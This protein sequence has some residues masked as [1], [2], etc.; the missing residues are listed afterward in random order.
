MSSGSKHSILSLAILAASLAYAAAVAARH[1]QS[2][3]PP[4]ARVPVHLVIPSS[5]PPLPPAADPHVLRVCADPN[6]MPFSDR[7]GRGFENKL[8]ELVGR[9]LGRRLEYYWQPQRRGFIRTTLTA[10]YCDLVIGIPSSSEMARVTRPYYRSTYVFVSRRHRQAPIRSLD[11]PRLRRLRI[12]VSITGQD[13]GNPPAAQAL[14][15]RRI[16]D[17]VHGYPV[18]GDYSTAH[19]S[20]GVVDALMRG[21]VDVAIAWGPIAGYVVRQEPGRFNITPVVDRGG[22]PF[23]FDI[24]MAVRGTDAALAFAIDDV[25]ARHAADIQR[26]LIS[27]G[28]PLASRQGVQG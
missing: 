6:N 17:N 11:D 3:V 4:A 25:I 8:A 15:N 18:F 28:V 24:S 23:A 20:S 19:P 2:T 21:Q 14:A 10:G 12:G 9:D 16:F 13:Y 5:E 7:G 27:Y 26:I 22:L 1:H